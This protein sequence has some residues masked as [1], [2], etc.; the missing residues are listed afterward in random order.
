MK[1]EE[2]AYILGTD[3]Q[4]LH[5]LGVQHQI[6]AMEAHNG[7]LNAGFTAGHTLLDLGCGPGF[8]TTEMAFIAARP[9]G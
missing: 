8:C 7:W 3:W 4:E 2:G 1:K 6:W 5:R 9:A